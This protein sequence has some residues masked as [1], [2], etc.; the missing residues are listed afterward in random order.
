MAD[1][2]QTARTIKPARTAAE[3]ETFLEGRFGQVEGL[4][5]LVDGHISQAFSFDAEGERLVIRFATSAEGYRR[6]AFAARTIAG[7]GLPVPPILEI[8]QA[9]DGWYALAPRAPGANLRQT[10]EAARRRLVGP[11][12]A[13]LRRLGAVVPPGEGYGH[14]DTDG[15]GT[16]SDWWEFLLSI[17]TPEST[18]LYAG[19]TDLFQAGAIDRQVWERLYGRLELAGRLADTPRGVVH[20]DFGGDNLIADAEEVTAV[21]EW[22]S[23]AYGDPLYDLANVT[24]WTPE[25]RYLEEYLRQEGHSVP[26]F[27][28]R[29]LAYELHHGLL[30]LRFFAVMDMREAYRFT[31]RR[32]LTALEG[33]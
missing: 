33:G 32:A 14:W 24:F 3:V 23:A 13:T 29:L 11:V 6:D 25:D 8:G 18:G 22:G 16:S 27:D 5:P 20:F 19:W 9:F 30:S 15:T 26:D 4:T 12:I 28:E 10:P 7:E 2:D 17:N 31:E 1:E 21:I